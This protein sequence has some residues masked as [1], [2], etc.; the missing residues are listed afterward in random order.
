MVYLYHIQSYQFGNTAIVKSLETRH[1]CLNYFYV[2]FVFAY[3]MILLRSSALSLCVCV[4]IM[5]SFWLAD[6][7][8]CFVLNLSY[9]CV[10]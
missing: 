7:F 9:S 4:C 10:L 6:W 2:F 1:S 3:S 5:S 8:E